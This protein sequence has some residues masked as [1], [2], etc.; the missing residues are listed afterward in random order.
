MHY[1]SRARLVRRACD[2]IIEYPIFIVL[3][4]LCLLRIFV[5]SSVLLLYATPGAPHPGNELIHIL[6][7]V[8]LNPVPDK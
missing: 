6:S 7:R 2:T 8:L 4:S 3:S 1:D 5:V